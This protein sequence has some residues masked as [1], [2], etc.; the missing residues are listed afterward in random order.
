[1]NPIETTTEHERVE[2]ARLIT[3]ALEEGSPGATFYRDPNPPAP[4]GAQPVAQP[5][6]PPMSQRATDISGVITATGLASLPIGGGAALVLWQL[7]HVSPT[8]LAIA[9]LAPIGLVSAIG[10]VAKVA[11]RAARETAEAL[12]PGEVHHHHHGPTS[13]HTDVHTENRGLLNIAT[14]ES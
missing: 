14:K 11:G 7:S 4:T 5:G 13:V 10:I 6:R 2:S 8:V 3:E 1:M 9:G 12:P